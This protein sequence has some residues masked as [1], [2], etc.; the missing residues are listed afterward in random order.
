[1][2]NYDS[3][4][5]YDDILRTAVKAAAATGPLVISPIPGTDLVVVGTIWGT[6]AAEIAKLNNVK[7]EKEAAVKI[8]VAVLTG[9]GAYAASVKAFLYIISKVP[10]I[11]WV[12]GSGVNSVANTALTLWFAFALI[13]LF[14]EDGDVV[15]LEGY[16]TFLISEV[17]PRN[18]GKKFARA[19]AFIKR[20]K[21]G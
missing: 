20:W 4:S 6:M 5:Y 8:A 13:D 7:L 1:M 18:N 16:V 11:G 12:A 17:R 19:A 21:Q 2:G 14:D 10:G 3:D 15:D 9:L